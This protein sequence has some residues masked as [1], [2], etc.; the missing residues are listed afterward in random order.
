MSVQDIILHWTHRY[1][2]APAINYNAIK[3]LLNDQVSTLT[4][5]VD[6]WGYPSMR[7][8][9]D[10]SFH[11]NLFTLVDKFVPE[12]RKDGE[13]V[14]SSDTPFIS[15]TVAGKIVTV[16]YDNPGLT[17]G[18]TVEVAAGSIG[19]HLL[20]SHRTDTQ[21]CAENAPTVESVADPAAPVEV[22]DDPSDTVPQTDPDEVTPDP[23]P[24][25]GT[26]PVP[27]A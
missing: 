2:R 24:T 5:A 19:N 25:G 11:S 17:V 6:L 12:V 4:V 21:V 8:S 10:Q 13:Q 23:N 18:D 1:L 14:I 16:V 20:L 22:D 26:T 27:N 7:L 15:R 9:G 3:I